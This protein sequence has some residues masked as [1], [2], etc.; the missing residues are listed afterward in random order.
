[1]MM[2]PDLSLQSSLK[3]PVRG[4]SFAWAPARGPVSRRAVRPSRVERRDIRILL[5]HAPGGLMLLQQPY[6]RDFAE[7][8]GPAP[9][10][11]PA[12]ESLIALHFEGLL[13]PLAQDLEV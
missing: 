5:I 10:R 13:L 7:K 1:M 12:P 6:S 8:V 9:G 11:G 2:P 3:S 4:A